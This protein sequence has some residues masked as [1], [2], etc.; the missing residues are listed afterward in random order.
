MFYF[1]NP[2]GGP[3]VYPYTLTDLRLANPT[4]KFPNDITDAQAA[5]Y[6][7]FPVQPTD[8]PAAPTGKKAVRDLPEDVD[9]MWFERWALVDLTAEET[10][11]QWVAVRAER[12]SKLAASDWTQLDDTPLTN[13]QKAEWAAYRQALRD[14]PQTQTDP[15][16]IVW[17]TVG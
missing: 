4:V 5:E 2:P 13:A 6:H 12:D 14:L 7:C 10:E 9:G 8:A 17:P 1:L 15:F 3:A 11:A 16:N